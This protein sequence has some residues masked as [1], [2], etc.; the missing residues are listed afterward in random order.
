[1]NAEPL[2]NICRVNFSRS[3]IMSSTSQWEVDTFC[4]SRSRRSSINH[5][6]CDGKCVFLPNEDPLLRVIKRSWGKKVKYERVER[7]SVFRVS[8]AEMLCMAVHDPIRLC[9]AN[10]RQCPKCLEAWAPLLLC[11]KKPKFS[12]FMINE[13]LWVRLSNSCHLLTKVT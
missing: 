7:N 1:M 12:W 4:Q 11:N 2:H 6:V 9:N 10:Q 3:R 5:S 8:D 13:I